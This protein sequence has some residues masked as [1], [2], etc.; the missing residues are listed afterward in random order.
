MKK[1][2]RTDGGWERL[3]ISN[4]FIF[5]KV[6]QDPG[7][8]QELLRR[9]LPDLEIGR[10]EYPE[11]QKG[12]RPDADAKSVRLDV[13]VK[14]GGDRVY[15]VEMQAADTKE[16]PK[17][18]R[19]YQGMLDLQMIDKGQRYRDLNPCYVIFICSFDAFGAGRHVYTFRNIC[20]EDKSLVL[21]DQTTKI[22]LNAAGKTDDA[23]GELKAF[24]DYVAGKKSEDP[25]VTELDKAVQKAKG[26]R[27][28]RREYMM[29]WMRDQE[30][31]ER[32]I[33]KGI[34]KG[35]KKGIKK[36]KRAGLR[37][38]REAGLKEGMKEAA[39]RMLSAGRYALEEIADI[40]G[41]SL[42]EVKKLQAE[43]NA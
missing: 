32:G 42:E 25:F 39:L 8:C 22:F 37:A 34:E 17:R 11:P 9:I 24:L 31:M 15:D 3:G 13:Y 7:L 23:S 28:W 33:E 19:Y 43:Q 16:L 5:G 38:G 30:N 2:N 18:S 10:V 21:D 36:G 26:N 20:V 14:G 12:I 1:R 35:I 6:M 27:E 4:D 40:S 41:L 29:L